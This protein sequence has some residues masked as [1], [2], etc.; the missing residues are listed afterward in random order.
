M[1]GTGLLVDELEKVAEFEAGVA[2]TVQPGVPPNLV[3]EP[4]GP[5][6]I[7]VGGDDGHAEAVDVQVFH[8]VPE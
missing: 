5:Q 4:D 2:S 8:R 7:G 3:A 6:T 1:R